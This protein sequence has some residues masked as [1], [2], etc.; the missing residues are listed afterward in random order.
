MVSV[1]VVVVGAGLSG[2]RAAT[3]LHLAGLSYAV[4]EATDRVGGK[5]LSNPAS[6]NVTGLVDMG[7]AW[8]NDS[9]QSEMFAL[10]EEFDFDLIVQ[11]P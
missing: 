8:I 3:Q 7:A 1:D 9:N 4:L 2:L 5:T 10:A 6:S 11:R